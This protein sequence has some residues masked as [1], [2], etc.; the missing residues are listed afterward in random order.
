MDINE[1][2]GQYVDKY[3]D[4]NPEKGQ[5][6]LKLGWKAQNF[7]FRHFPNKRLMPADRYLADFMMQA[8]RAPLQDPENSAIVSIFVPCEML[9]EAGLNPYNAEAYSC[10][11]EA[12]KVERACLQQAE[13]KACPRP[14]AV[15]TVHLS[16][17]RREV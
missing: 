2:F 6:L 7:K 5:K 17:Q 12:S 16:E 3:T 15:I 10:Y 8:M 14:Y 9:Q 13:M 4:Q 1:I 11:L